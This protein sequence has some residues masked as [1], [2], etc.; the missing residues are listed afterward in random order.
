MKRMTGVGLPFILLFIV[1]AIIAPFLV[2]YI[3]QWVGIQ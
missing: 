3:S 1:M 2:M